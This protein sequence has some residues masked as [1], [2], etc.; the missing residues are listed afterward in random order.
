MARVLFDD[1][2]LV[3]F[4]SAMLVLYVTI[5]GLA[6][7]FA[8]EIVSAKF[9]YLLVAKSINFRYSL[10]PGRDILKFFRTLSAEVFLCERNFLL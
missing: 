6:G 7:C 1:L 8:E 5:L 3:L 2:H 9:L 10:M 4:C